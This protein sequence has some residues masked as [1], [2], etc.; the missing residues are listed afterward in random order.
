MTYVLRDRE[1]E[2]RF[3]KSFTSMYFKTFSVSHVT[4]PLVFYTAIDCL[5][6]IK[7]FDLTYIYAYSI[8][9]SFLPLSVWISEYLLEFVKNR[10]LGLTRVLTFLFQRRFSSPTPPPPPPPFFSNHFTFL[11]NFCRCVLFL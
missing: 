6:F 9:V 2:E 3:L 1:V 5:Q 7:S 11:T 10:I 8:I 4:D